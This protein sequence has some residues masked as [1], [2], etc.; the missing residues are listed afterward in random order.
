MRCL[1]RTESDRKITNE[2]WSSMQR[3][4]RTNK[5][6]HRSEWRSLLKKDLTGPT[7]LEMSGNPAT[8]ASGPRGRDFPAPATAAENA[9]KFERSFQNHGD[10][11]DHRRFPVYCLFSANLC[12][13]SLWSKGSV[14]SDDRRIR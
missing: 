6:T 14:R 9:S 4:K 13:C 7:L 12:P 10:F 11:S 5:T 1:G 2:P 3:S 8:Q